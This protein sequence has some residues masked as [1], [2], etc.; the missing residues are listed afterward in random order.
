MIEQKV[1]QALNEAD[2]DK[3]GV[4]YEVEVDHTREKEG[5]AKF[6]CKA[7]MLKENIETIDKELKLGNGGVI[8]SDLK[9]ERK[10]V[11]PPKE[12]EGGGKKVKPHKDWDHGNRSADTKEVEED[13]KKEIGEGGHITVYSDEGLTKHLVG[14]QRPNHRDTA[15]MIMDFYK[16]A[17][18]VDERVNTIYSTWEESLEK[19]RPVRKMKPKA[20]GE[21]KKAVKQQLQNGVLSLL[22]LAY[23]K[24]WTLDES[25]LSQEIKENIN[26]IKLPK[27][28]EAIGKSSNTNEDDHNIATKTLKPLFVELL[29]KYNKDMKAVKEEGKPP[30]NS[31]Q[32]WCKKRAREEDA[33]GTP[34]PKKKKGKK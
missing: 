13:W 4:Y 16:V 2:N 29:N 11:I 27:P 9:N 25:N 17:D 26:H 6:K 14:G 3:K 23:A 30:P 12:G 32:K 19:G 28:P 31:V 1:K 5:K 18:K 8:E 33:E 20:F 21:T 10:K 24:G 22:G 34:A 7:A 15:Q